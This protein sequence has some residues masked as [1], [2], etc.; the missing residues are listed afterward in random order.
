M[1]CS[2]VFAQ[3]YTGPTAKAVIVNFDNSLKTIDST[4]SVGDIVRA[5]ISR[6]GTTIELTPYEVN[7]GVNQISFSSTLQNGDE[8]C[9]IASYFGGGANEDCKEIPTPGLGFVPI[10]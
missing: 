6:N 4:G 1:S 5:K 10:T 2:N 9:V 7:T 8:L 3:R